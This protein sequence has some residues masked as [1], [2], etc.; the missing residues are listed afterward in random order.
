[1]FGKRTAD[2]ESKATVAAPPM[3]ASTGAPLATR[4]QRVEPATAKQALAAPAGRR[5]PGPAHNP[6]P[7]AWPA[8]TPRRSPRRPAGLR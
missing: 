5:S 1:M 3:A 4:P 8:P 6:P 7:T 2:G